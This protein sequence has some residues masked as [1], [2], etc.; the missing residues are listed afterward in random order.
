M[1]WV[2]APGPTS[3][4]G[5]YLESAVNPHG[6]RHA[7]NRGSSPRFCGQHETSGDIWVPFAGWVLRDT[8]RTTA[9]LL[10]SPHIHLEVSTKTGIPFRTTLPRI[11]LGRK[12][13]KRDL[14]EQKQWG[15][16]L[17]LCCKSPNLKKP[18]DIQSDRSQFWVPT[19]CF[20]L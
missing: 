16:H 1:S 4:W 11:E 14:P 19:L 9:I 12:M 10:G 2:T 18:R 15:T 3:S 20:P 8:K 5:W 13:N 7:A 17:N 6:E